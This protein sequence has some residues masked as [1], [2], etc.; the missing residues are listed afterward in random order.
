VNDKIYVLYIITKLELGGAQ[1]VCL[2]L[3]NGLLKEGHESLLISGPEGI[4]VNQAIQTGKMYLIKSFNREVGL[5]LIW[6]EIKTFFSLIKIIRRFKKEYKNL[7]VHTHST[8]ACILGRWAAIFAGVKVRIHTVHGYGFHEFMPSY[9]WVTIFLS[10]YITSFIT[11]HFICVST[12]DRETG[13]S[14]FPGFAKKSSVIRAS[15]DDR[16]FSP[17]VKEPSKLRKKYLVIGTVSCFKQQKNIFDLL[18][19]FKFVLDSYGGKDN[20]PIMLEIIGDGIL[21]QSIEQWIISNN[22][23]KHI[24]LWGWQ[25]NILP[26]LKTWDVFVISSLWEGLPCAV[27]EA[28]LCKL[29]IIAYDVGGIYEIVKNS[30][31]GFLIS[32]EDWEAFANKLLL[33]ISNSSLRTR[34]GNFHDNLNDFNNQVMVQQHVALYKKLT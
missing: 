16:F 31:N 18:K 15:V 27:V 28:R 9:K 1:K 23:E 8:K 12:K 25:D 21:R 26:F 34:M 5:K 10:E 7:I 3:L 33:V 22:L 29:P 17:Y 11:T 20:Y 6:A 4:L 32:P 24:T 13:I 14:L 19:A 30:K 2:S